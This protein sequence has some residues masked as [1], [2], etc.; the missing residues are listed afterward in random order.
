M[1]DD[2]PPTALGKWVEGI[3]LGGT[4]V[5]DPSPKE[6]M[7]STRDQ[8]LALAMR[9]E[10]TGI[11]KVNA[12]A[13]PATMLYKKE[14]K[15]LQNILIGAIKG[16]QDGEVP[17]IRTI[18][19][20]LE[21]YSLEARTSIRENKE[22][23]VVQCPT[24]FGQEKLEDK[25]LKALA[26]FSKSLGDS[27]NIELRLRFLNTFHAESGDKYSEA[28][29]LSHLF[30]LLPKGCQE[31][32][33]TWAL[34]GHQLQDVFDRLMLSLSTSLSL[35]QLKEK[36]GA[37]ETQ[38]I[39]G[40]KKTMD[41]LLDVENLAD[42]TVADKME[43]ERLSL[44]VGFKLIGLTCDQMTSVLIKTTASAYMVRKF[45]DLLTLV[46]DE[47]QDLITSKQLAK[48]EAERQNRRVHQ[49]VPTAEIHQIQHQDNFAAL[50]VICYRCQAPGHLARDCHLPP[51]TPRG[52]QQRFPLGGS[53][54]QEA[55][56]PYWSERCHRHRGTHLNHECGAKNVPCALAGHGGH[57]QGVCR[58][59]YETRREQIRRQYPYGP[60]QGPGPLGRNVHHA[61]QGP[62][63]AP[64]RQQPQQSMPPAA[65][66]SGSRGPP[67]GWRQDPNTPSRPAYGYRGPPQSGYRRN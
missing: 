22:R 44:E 63:N 14:D 5:K 48:Q 46:K 67:S 42:R 66:P 31:R 60:P 52:P 18:R 7:M 58:V 43:I 3:M 17:T 12:D 16:F 27:A 35:F 59:P 41:L 8:H 13:V 11:C 29:W 10:K 56:Q 23:I 49:V 64:M 65:D 36:F 30:L 32:A 53:R 4:V 21:S 19:E 26:L 15:S 33:S 38:A 51:A 62:W 47:F 24:T 37:L 45:I 61:S 50:G 25:D 1:T 39:N 55:G 28:T 40:T 57:T 9:L 34:N 20:S 2:T 54:P 6:D